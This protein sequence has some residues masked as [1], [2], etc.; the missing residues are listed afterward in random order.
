[1]KRSRFAAVFAMFLGIALVAT[2]CSPRYGH[3]GNTY[4]APAPEG[5]VVL[6]QSQ[7]VPDLGEGQGAAVRDGFVY[8]YGDAETGVIREYR[9][10]ADEAGAIAQLVPTGR[11]V[12]LTA[13]GDDIIPHPTGLTFH[14]EFGTFLGDTV[15]GKGTIY[16]IDWD[17]ALSDGTLDRAVLN[18]AH[19]DLAVNGCRPEFVRVGER[20]LVATAD[21]GD[22]DNALRLYDPKR[23]AEAAL[24]SQDGV[25]VARQPCPPFVQ[26]M[27]YDDPTRRLVLAQN[28]IAG[29]RYRLTLYAVDDMSTVEPISMVDLPQP[30]DELEGFCMLPS[31]PA[32]QDCILFSSAREQNVW[33]A[34]IDLG[35]A[36]K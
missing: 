33:F 23:L 5:A 10:E 19:D 13:G 27:Y 36:R 22:R 25:L 34:T 2:S 20:W 31:T 12:R 4:I 30:T 7:T 26:S 15:R 6:G 29:L 17:A 24:T 18:V 9:C 32:E 35:G 1:M 14:P 16:H 3:Y 11:A 28:Q 8:L 21:Y